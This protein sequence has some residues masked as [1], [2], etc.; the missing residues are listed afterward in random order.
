MR[1][2]RTLAWLGTID[3]SALDHIGRHPALGEVSLEN[4]LVAIYGHQLLHMRD[5]QSKLGPS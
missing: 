4:M 2:E 5:L 3:E 1:P